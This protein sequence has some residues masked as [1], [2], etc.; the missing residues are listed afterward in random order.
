MNPS[1][2]IRE[3]AADVHTEAMRTLVHVCKLAEGR[4]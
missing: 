2:A 3:T 4:A 1:A